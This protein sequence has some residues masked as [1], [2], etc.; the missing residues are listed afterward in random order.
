MQ[1]LIKLKDKFD[2]AFACDTDHLNKILEEV[3][4]IVIKAMS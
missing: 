4:S 3:Q 2:V 1:G